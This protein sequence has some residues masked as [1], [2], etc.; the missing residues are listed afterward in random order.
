MGFSKRIVDL[1]QQ[2][3]LID[4]VKTDVPNKPAETDS[5]PTIE[6]KLPMSKR[7]ARSLQSQS[8]LNNQTSLLG[9]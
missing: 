6:T 2:S 8:Q 1:I 7:R 4:K 9:G 3:K 5:K